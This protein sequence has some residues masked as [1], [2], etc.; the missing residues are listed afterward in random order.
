ME[1]RETI[2]VTTEEFQELINK[3]FEPDYIYCGCDAKSKKIKLQ[4]YL[5]KIVKIIK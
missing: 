4:K 3:Y 1:T 2:T 5:N